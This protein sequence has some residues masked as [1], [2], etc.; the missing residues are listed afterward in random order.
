MV[1]GSLQALIL[2]AFS[3]SKNSDLGAEE[4]R[5]KNS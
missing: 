1:E 5:E 4:A 3:D 2:L